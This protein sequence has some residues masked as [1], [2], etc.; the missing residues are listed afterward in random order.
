MT[1]G[2]A[3]VGLS[4]DYGAS[5]FLTQLVGSAKARELFFTAER[6]DAATC[7]SLGIVNRVVPPAR[8]ED[9]DDHMTASYFAPV[10]PELDLD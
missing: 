8:L 9:V 3:N 10:T 6:V 1:T 2:F 4:G 5:F 7:L